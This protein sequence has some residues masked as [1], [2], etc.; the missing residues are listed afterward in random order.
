L[1]KASS[2]FN[3]EDFVVMN[4]DML[5]NLD[6]NKL[7]AAH[8]SSQALATLAVMQR[9]SSRQLLFDQSMQLCGWRNNNT[10]E[11]KASRPIDNTLDLA[12]SGIQIINASFFQ[13]NE[14]SGKFSII[15]AYLKMAES[16]S[17]KGFDHTGDLILDV[18]KPDSLL[19]AEQLFS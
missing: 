12:F 3:D 7:I 8:Q 5:T 4:V 9:S 6:L 1:L 16:L 19:L 10:G 11:T 15:D 14:H 18:G 17:I 2:F 13:H